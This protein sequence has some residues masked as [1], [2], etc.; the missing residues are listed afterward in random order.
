[1][2]SGLSVG[3]EYG[4]QGI[5]IKAG[6]SN[7][8]SE[9]MIVFMKIFRPASEVESGPSTVSTVSAPAII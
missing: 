1:M 8:G 9:S 7:H 2:R 3:T 6:S 4:R 5:G